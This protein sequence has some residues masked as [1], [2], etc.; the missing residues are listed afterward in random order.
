MCQCST[1]KHKTTNRVKVVKRTTIHSKTYLFIEVHQQQSGNLTHSLAV[2]DVRVVHRVCSQHVK[3]RLLPVSIIKSHHI[4]PPEA[5]VSKKYYRNAA[6]YYSEKLTKISTTFSSTGSQKNSVLPT[7]Q[8][9]SKQWRNKVAVGPRASIP[10]GPPL[11]QKKLYKKTASGK[12]WAPH[13]AGPA[14]TARLARPIV[15]PLSQR[16]HRRH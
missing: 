16:D 9:I 15:M 6:L 11:P 13:S 14:C 12:F 8:F 1:I 5:H 2:T 4:R 10:K 3:Q 7:Q